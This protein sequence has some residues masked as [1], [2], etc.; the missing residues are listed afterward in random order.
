MSLPVKTGLP[1]N[2]DLGGGWTVRFTAVNAST[3]A[4]DTSVVVSKVSITVADTG[5]AGLG[6]GPFMLVPGPGA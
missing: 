3:G 5:A 2:L 4:V 6:V 1:D